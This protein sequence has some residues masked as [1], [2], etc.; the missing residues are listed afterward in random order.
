M[1]K[2]RLTDR[3]KERIQAIQNKRRERAGRRADAKEQDLS[4]ALGPEQTGRVI[5]HHGATLIVESADG[6][7]YRCVQ[8]QNMEALV[9]GDHVIWQATRD[10]KT[11]EGVIVALRP[12]STLLERPEA[13]GS[14]RPVAAN[15]D[16]IIIVAAPQP[17]LSE[18]LI[19][20]YLVNAEAT[21]ITPIIL[22]NKIDLL[23]AKDKAILER[24]LHVYI[25]IGYRII[26]AS[27]KQEHGL[28]TLAAQLAGNTSILVGQ[29]GVG[30]SSLVKQ[31]LPDL[32]IRIGAL[33]ATTLGKHTTTTSVLYHLPFSGD[34]IDSP[35]IR[36]FG[37]WHINAD[38]ILHGFVEFRPFLGRC[39]FSNCSHSVE[40]GCALKI[41]VERGEIQAKR[42]ASYRSIMEKINA[43]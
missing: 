26:Y 5:S 42:L 9:C 16:Q 11:K 4:S 19:D 13:G 10:H 34:L 38:D 2:R 20:R 43:M 15:L 40:P 29:S 23:S 41:A 6:Q 25:D 37:V 22:I 32:D 24:R 3:Q 8:R 33:S 17:S 39:K 14:T 18:Q 21:H 36:D 1:A 7:L 27:V 30:K 12:R 28:D 35:G 31:L